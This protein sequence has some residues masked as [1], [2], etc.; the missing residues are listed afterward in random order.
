MRDYRLEEDDKNYVLSYKKDEEDGNLLVK[1][2][3]DGKKST[4]FEGVPATSVNI[5]NL[6]IKM[7]SQI[8]EAIKN[9]HRFVLSRNVSLITSGLA[10]ASSVAASYYLFNKEN[11]SAAV[12]LC[13]CVPTFVY[14][15]KDYIKENRKVKELKKAECIK[16]NKEKL[17]NIKKYPNALAGVKDKTKEFISSY[18]E[19]FKANNLDKINQEDIDKIIANIEREEEFNFIYEKKEN[20]KIKNYVI[21]K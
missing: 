15:L 8:E 4:Y 1:F 10:F 7:Q 21:G 20:P 3:D 13:V 2:A 5:K 16:I 11:L 9:K 17:D 14:C 12:L 19:P 6:D 18:E